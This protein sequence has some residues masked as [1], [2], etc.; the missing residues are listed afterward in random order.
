MNETC[1]ICLEE[2]TEGEEIRELPC[3]HGEHLINI[4]CSFCHNVAMRVL[5]HTGTYNHVATVHVV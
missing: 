1:A 5:A 2:F 3:L 4:V